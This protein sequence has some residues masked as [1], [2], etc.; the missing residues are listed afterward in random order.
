[1]HNTRTRVH[2]SLEESGGGQTS[3]EMKGTEVLNL[4]AV[5]NISVIYCEKACSYFTWV[6]VLYFHDNVYTV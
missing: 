4:G 3:A 2:F 6:Y 5:Q 1:M